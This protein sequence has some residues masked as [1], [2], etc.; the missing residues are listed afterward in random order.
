[1]FDRRA[2]L[3]FDIYY[4]NVSHQQLTAT[5]GSAN[6]TQLLNADHTIGKGAELE[7]Q[8]RPLSNLQ[9]SLSGAYNYTRIEDPTLATSESTRAESRWSGGDRHRTPAL[10]C[11]ALP[12]PLPRSAGKR[13]RGLHRN[14]TRRNTSSGSS[15]GLHLETR[16]RRGVPPPRH[17]NSLAAENA[18]ARP[19]IRAANGAETP[20]RPRA[21]R[22]LRTDAYRHRPGDS[23]HGIRFPT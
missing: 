14:D 11:D 5:G 1:M 18:A 3:A 9:V 6:I 16:M 13:H 23:S 19:A 10:Q 21:R 2:T 8:V 20:P 15:Q 22:T 7:F 12:A 17:T 4:Y